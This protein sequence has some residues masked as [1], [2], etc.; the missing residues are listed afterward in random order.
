M[1][2][3][4]RFYYLEEQPFAHCEPYVSHF[5]YRRGLSIGDR[6]LLCNLLLWYFWIVHGYSRCPGNL[7]QLPFLKWGGRGVS[8]L[9]DAFPLVRTVL[10]PIFA[11]SYLMIRIVF[12]GIITCYYFRDIWQAFQDNHTELNYSRRL[13]LYLNSLSLGFLTLLQIIWLFD[14]FK[15]L[16]G[17]YKM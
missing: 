15:I 3:S 13:F 12:W 9:G 4:C 5:L 7:R 10:G 11:L 17:W 2:K 14:I 6:T 1:Q 16:F 8:G